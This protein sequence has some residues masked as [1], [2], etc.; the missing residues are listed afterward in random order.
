MKNQVTLFKNARIYL[1]DKVIN[2]GWILVNEIGKIVEIGEG[3]TGTLN[4]DVIV[5]GEGMSLIPGLIDVHIHGGNG[6]SFMDGS[7]EALAEISSFM[8]STGLHLF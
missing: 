2:Q 4:Y 7:Y 6:Y 5:D 8:L 3:N 1:L